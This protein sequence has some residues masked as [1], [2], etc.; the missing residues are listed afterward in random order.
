M[1][2]R[3][4]LTRIAALAPVTVFPVVGG[5]A[6]DA[7]RYLRLRPEIE[8]VRSPRHASVLLIAGDF[9][10]DAWDSI[11][12]VHDQLPTPRTS[13]AWNRSLGP[14]GDGLAVTGDDHDLIHGVL[15]AANA[16]L[17]DP[18]RSEPSIRPDVDPVDWRGVGP[19]G[20]GG[21]GKT[22][23]T[24]F[25]RPLAERAGDRDGLE[26]DQLPITIGPW[27]GA[28]PWG[29]QLEFKLQ[30]DLIQAAEFGPAMIGPPT[31]GV[32]TAAMSSPVAVSD[33]ELER[34]KTHLGW[35]SDALGVHGLS[36]L[37]L[38]TLRIAEQLT[39]DH[40]SEVDS[41]FRMIRRSGIFQLS[42]KRDRTSATR[43][44]PPGSGP[45]RRAAGIEEDARLED[46]T[47]REIG[48]T[49]V[50]Q[51]GGTTADRWRQRMDETRQSLDL[52]RRA[53]DRVAFGNGFVE[54]PT[55][56]LTGDNTNTSSQVLDAV[57]DL[58]AGLEWGDAI[59]V[60]WSLDLDPSG[61]VERPGAAAERV[62]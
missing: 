17:S 15:T 59:S 48:F 36:A 23:G 60:L 24:P 10:D 52:I 39:P 58:L 16:A 47:Y 3:S 8:F 44:F 32:F 54:G 43:L 13:V 11:A 57:P 61:I 38:R 30:G 4:V 26:L 53:S 45:L 49:P 50:V 2:L 12:L 19:Y 42:L 7:V 20:H 18:S 51:A 31:P 5:G 21:K 46:R 22:G 41:L 62:V 28:L 40:S 37:G 56:R 1:G 6:R 29:L 33:L 9:T 35:L 55:G 34:A 14:I 27:I 25:G